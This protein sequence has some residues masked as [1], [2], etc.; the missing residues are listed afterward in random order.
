MI[1][2]ASVAWDAVKTR[3]EVVKRARKMSRRRL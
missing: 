2:V 3:A 1:Y